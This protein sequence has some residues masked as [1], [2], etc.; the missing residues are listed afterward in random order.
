MDKTVQ[1]YL[2]NLR[3]EEI[4]ENEK[5]RNFEWTQDFVS[6]ALSNI[7]GQVMKTIFSCSTSTFFQMNNEE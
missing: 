2:V 7:G 5:K 1:D 6:M 4:S 3:N